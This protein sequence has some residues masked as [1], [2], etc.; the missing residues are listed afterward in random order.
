MVLPAYARA[1]AL[2]QN[3]SAPE[4]R[5]E[6]DSRQRKAPIIIILNVKKVIEYGF[7]P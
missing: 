7:L 2:P 6:S 4:I 5:S 3:A 1:M